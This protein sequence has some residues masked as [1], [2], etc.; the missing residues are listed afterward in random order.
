MAMQADYFVVLLV[1]LVTIAVFGAGCSAVQ[2][3]R[4]PGTASP[5]TKT[6]T[7]TTGVQGVSPTMSGGSMSA[8]SFEGEGSDDTMTF[9]HGP[10]SARLTYTHSGTDSFQV[11]LLDGHGYEIDLLVD[12]YG[13][14]SDWTD[15]EFDEWGLYS[16]GVDADGE[17]TLDIT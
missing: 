15:F 17:W 12:D 3:N 13:R 9:T 4:A 7:V 5:V 1:L 8:L 10:G 16:F 14:V 11:W 2:E 6:S